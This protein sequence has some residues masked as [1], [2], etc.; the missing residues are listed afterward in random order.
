MVAHIQGWAHALEHVHARIAPRFH[1]AEPRRRTVRSL[2]AWLSPVERKT[3]WHRAE[4]LGA[5]SPDGV[6]RLLNAADGDAD[7]VRDDLRASVV[8]HLADP[9]AVLISDEPGL[10]KTGTQAVGVKRH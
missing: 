5:A 8:E 4:Q 1:R 2:H 10:L 3:G 9:D 6:P 7:A